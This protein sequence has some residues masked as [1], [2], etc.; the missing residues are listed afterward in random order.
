VLVMEAAEAQRKCYVSNTKEVRQTWQLWR[1][2]S[3]VNFIQACIRS[4]IECDQKEPSLTN[5]SDTKI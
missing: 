1:A 3:G 2:L 5:E 4:M